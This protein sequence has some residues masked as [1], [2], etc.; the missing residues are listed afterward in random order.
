MRAALIPPCGAEYT[1]LSSDI[2]LVLPLPE[3]VENR[4]YI[5]AYRAAWNRGDYLILDNGC[6]EGRLVPNEALLNFAQRIHAQE[7]VAPDVMGDATATVQ[8]TLAFF[9]DN[10][11]ARNFAVMGVLQGRNEDEALRVAD[12]YSRIPGITTVGIPK[13]L[14]Q[15]G[16]HIRARI[17]RK[18]LEYFPNRFDIH[19]LGLSS[20]FQ[21]EML[22]VKFPRAV[23]SMDSA[24]PYKYTEAGVWMTALKVSKESVHRRSSYFSR[25]VGYDAPMLNHNIQTFLDWA[26]SNES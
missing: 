4:D 5:G 17:A 26:K 9:K 23:R 10:P 3:C 24:Q 1:I 18:V 19:L 21:T 25:P 22:D 15:A 11:R 16:S 12:S 2:H 13:V 6:A 7:I 20:H 14:V 8:R